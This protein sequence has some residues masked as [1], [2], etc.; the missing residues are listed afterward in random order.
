MHQH[1]KRMVSN[2]ELYYIVIK[3]KISKNKNDSILVIQSMIVM[4]Y[5]HSVRIVK[6]IPTR[7]CHICEPMR[8]SNLI[9]VGARILV[10]IVQ[11]LRTIEHLP[12]SNSITFVN[13]DLLVVTLLSIT[14]LIII[15]INFVRGFSGTCMLF[16][17]IIF[18]TKSHNIQGF[19]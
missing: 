9:L 4:P 17:Q 6:A 5:L 16:S 8:C 18:P 12:S 11:N 10:P 15:T 13:I 2:T 3:V 1:N 14:S 7:Q 19:W